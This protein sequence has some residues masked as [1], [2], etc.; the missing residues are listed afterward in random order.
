VSAAPQIPLN[1]FVYLIKI[2]RCVR[3][4]N[5]RARASAVAAVPTCVGPG[6]PPRYETT[7]YTDYMIRYQARTYNVFDDQAKDAAE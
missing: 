2:D 1:L 7:Y 4:V 6:R 5:C 3:Y